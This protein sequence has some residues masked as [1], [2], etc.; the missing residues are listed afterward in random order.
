MTAA[1]LHAPRASLAATLTDTAHALP[2]ERVSLRQLLE[3]IGEQGMLVFCLLLTVPFLL[4]VSIPGVSTPFGLLI[5]FIG[6]GVTFNR[7]P[8]LP[9]QL[10][11]RHF[12]TAQIAP[13]LHKA[14]TLLAKLDRLIRPRM[15]TFTGSRGVHRLNG[16]LIIVAAA[17]LMLP[18]GAIPFTNALPAWSILLLTA[19]MLQRDGMVVLAAWL[20]VSA[21][22]V[23]FTLLGIGLLQAGEQA[24]QLLG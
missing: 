16:L 4:P 18:L 3:L 14:A 5:L 13:M 1:E 2:S 21:T 9:E 12:A 24:Q 22:L 11:N 7:V 15:L 19:G 20:L 8:W 10:M 6:V 23:W 17:L